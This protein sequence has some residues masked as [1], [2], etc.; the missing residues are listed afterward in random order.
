LNL[1]CEY[2]SASDA[3][4]GDEQYADFIEHRHDQSIYSL[5]CKKA[6][7]VPF[8]SP[9]VFGELGAA[10]AVMK[11]T[12]LVYKRNLQFNFVEFENSDFPTMLQVNK[13]FKFLGININVFFIPY[14]YFKILNIIPFK[15][16]VYNFL[17][18]IGTRGI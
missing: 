12:A 1:A 5:L 2:D 14:I 9:F 11:K 15:S 7:L 13:E 3:K 6:K 16:K 4:V 10:Y 8:R 18:K 17:L